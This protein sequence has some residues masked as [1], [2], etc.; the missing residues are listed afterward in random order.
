MGGK[1]ASESA[2]IALVNRGGASVDPCWQGGSGGSAPV[3]EFVDGVVVEIVG[4]LQAIVGHDVGLLHDSGVDPAFFDGVERFGIF[5]EGDDGYLA[6]EI[7]T[8]Q[9]VGYA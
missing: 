6:G 8:M 7:D 3:F 4:K 5:V 2:D 1:S 9:R